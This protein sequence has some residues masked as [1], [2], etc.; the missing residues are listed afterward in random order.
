MQSPGDAAGTAGRVA[1]TALLF[2]GDAVVQTVLVGTAQCGH[3]PARMVAVNGGCGQSG[4]QRDVR[5]N[6]VLTWSVLL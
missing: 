1:A 4:V 3:L 6:A 5:G 2:R